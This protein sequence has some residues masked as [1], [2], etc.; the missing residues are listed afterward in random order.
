MAESK[1]LR[2]PRLW[3]RAP[4][5]LRISRALGRQIRRSKQTP[6]FPAQVTIPQFEMADSKSA[7]QR[8]RPQHA[9]TQAP[10]P[11]GRRVDCTRPR[12]ISHR[13]RPRLA[14]TQASAATIQ[15]RAATVQTATRHDPD[16]CWPTLEAI[17]HIPRTRLARGGARPVVAQRRAS[18]ARGPPMQDW[19]RWPGGKGILTSQQEWA[20]KEPRE[21]MPSQ[22][23]SCTV[24]LVR[25][26]GLEVIAILPPCA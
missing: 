11:T 26:E 7:V 19:K 4:G 10:S 5:F 2:M 21:P 9:H 23:G 3:R 1:A 6:R 20:P 18:F 22:T 12:F 24:T 25:S 16:L 14:H 17:S 8:S 15:G 13:P